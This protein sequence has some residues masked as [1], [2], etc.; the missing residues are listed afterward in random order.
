MVD[1]YTKFYCLSITCCQF[2]DWK[3]IYYRNHITRSVD[4]L[5][6]PCTL[7]RYHWDAYTCVKH[8][9]TVL[10]LDCKRLPANSQACNITKLLGGKER[11]YIGI[12]KIQIKPLRTCISDC[13]RLLF[14]NRDVN[15]L[16]VR[17][18]CHTRMITVTVTSW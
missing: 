17:Q 18:I 16:Y 14:S 15:E 5:P 9:Y 10:S 11:L 8:S 7:N 13:C 1:I 3:D 6:Y 4:N 2:C 12:C